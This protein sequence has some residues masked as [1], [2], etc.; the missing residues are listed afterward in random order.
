LVINAYFSRTKPQWLFEHIP[1]LRQRATRGEICFGPVDSW[2][3]YQ[4]TCGQL[5]ITDASKAARTMLYD[6]HKRTWDTT[7]LEAI[8]IPRE[9]LPE[10]GVSSHPYG[11]TNPATMLGAELPVAG[12][13]GDRQD[14]LSGRACFTLGMVKHAYKP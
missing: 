5:H 6:I 1:G 13:A 10:V 12:I 11:L 7:L 3:A 9:I 8:Q 4:M 14:A 2:L